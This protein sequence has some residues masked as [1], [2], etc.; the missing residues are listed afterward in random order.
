MCGDSLAKASQPDTIPSA[1]T[2]TFRQGKDRK[3]PGPTINIGGG[4]LGDDRQ[5]AAQ[6][7]VRSIL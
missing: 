7:A 4:N 6:H 3:P 5:T 2:N 1:L